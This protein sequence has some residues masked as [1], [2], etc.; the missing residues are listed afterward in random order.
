MAGEGERVLHG[1]RLSLDAGELSRRADALAFALAN[2]R[3]AGLEPDAQTMA[4]LARVARGE[5]DISDV[6]ESV[7]ARIAAGEFRPR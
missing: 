4:D 7:R 1:A 2:T 3:L 5:I 6:L